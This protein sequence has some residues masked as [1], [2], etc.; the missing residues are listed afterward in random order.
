MLKFRLNFFVAA[1][2]CCLVLVTTTVHGYPRLNENF[3][4]IPFEDSSPTHM[5][6]TDRDFEYEPAENQIDVIK[7]ESTGDANKDMKSKGGSSYL[8]DSKKSAAVIDPDSRKS[9]FIQLPKFLSFGMGYPYW[10]G[11]PHP[12][13][14][15]QPTSPCYRPRPK[16][17]CQKRDCCD[18]P[19]LLD[20]EDDTPADYMEYRRKRRY[21]VKNR[22][23][24]EAGDQ[25][26]LPPNV[27]LIKKTKK[28]NKEKREQD[29]DFWYNARMNAANEMRSNASGK[30]EAKK[31]TKPVVKS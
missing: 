7:K 11:P 16:C 6:L 3:L 12:S 26:E 1:V 9:N 30:K 31:P 20:E 24:D 2:T 25:E 8:S 19:M 23:D 4:E 5:Q 10:N 22:Q 15:H 17:G 14:M 13:A 21:R 27:E 18:P 29:F 28:L